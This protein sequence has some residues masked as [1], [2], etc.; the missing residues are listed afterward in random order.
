M[1]PCTTQDLD[2]G[3]PLLFLPADIP[4]LPGRNCDVTVPV[5]DDTAGYAALTAPAGTGAGKNEAALTAAMGE[6][7]HVLHAGGDD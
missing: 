2:A 7:V 6:G 5:R 1:P 4:A 3:V